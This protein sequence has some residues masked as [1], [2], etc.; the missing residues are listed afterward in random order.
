MAA[1][2]SRV[3]WVLCSTQGV[4]FVTTGTAIMFFRRNTICGVVVEELIGIFIGQCW[5]IT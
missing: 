1:L 5:I 3:V 4:D 2:V